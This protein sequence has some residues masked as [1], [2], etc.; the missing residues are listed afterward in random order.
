MLWNG[1]HDAPAL[2]AVSLCQTRPAATTQ[3][4]LEEDGQDLKNVVEMYRT[5]LEFASDATG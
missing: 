3:S 1:A 4:W 5:D 2:A